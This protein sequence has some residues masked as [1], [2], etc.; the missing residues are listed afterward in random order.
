M[1]TILVQQTDPGTLEVITVALQFEGFR[2]CG[3]IDYDENI[4][5]MIKRHHPKLVLLDC[6]LKYYSGRQISHWIRAHFPGLP[7][8]ALSCNNDIDEHYMTLGFNDFL[9]KPLDL[10]QLY[11]VVRKHLYP[12]KRNPG[13]QVFA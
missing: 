6:R 5:A 4:L 2:V 9:K 8:I 7:L 11:Q 13:K 12:L 10:E 3:L 1:E